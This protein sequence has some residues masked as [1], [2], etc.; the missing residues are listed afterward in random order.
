[1]VSRLSDKAGS[2]RSPVARQS[3]FQSWVVLGIGLI[4]AGVW[5]WLAQYLGATIETASIAQTMGVY[6]ALLFA[7][8][9]ALAWVL[10]RAERRAVW[11]AGL[12]PARW[13]SRGIALGLGGLAVTVGFAALNGG[14]IRGEAGG[15]S[16]G[17]LLVGVALTFFQ[18]F[19][20]ELLFR[21][22]LQQAL[23][24]RVGTLA[25][26]GIGAVLFAAFHLG[27]GVRVPVSLF[28][29]MLGG[30]W[31]GLL[32]LR[33]GGLIAP[34]AAHFA[35]N[36]VEDLGVGLTPNP[37]TGPL[38][39]FIDLDLS[40]LPIWGGQPEALNASIGTSLVLLALILP[41]LQFPWQSAA[42]NQ[43]T[44]TRS[45]VPGET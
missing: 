16:A 36:V 31:F 45:L 40:G 9:I 14:L 5:V 17:F 32:A 35:W 37:G 44:A 15:I 34:L 43:A 33:S 11:C 28:N 7:P 39:A 23:I 3:A 6:Y 24:A 4:A 29:L 20:E 42:K 2:L 10:G 22:W 18:V 8:L 1:M 19:A 12:A 27:A 41:L 26:V 21:G 13:F 38:G 25:G 30:I